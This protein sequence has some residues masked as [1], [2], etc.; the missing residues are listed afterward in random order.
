MSKRRA[1]ETSADI[2]ERYNWKRL[3]TPRAWAPKAGDELAGYYLG[4]TLRDGAFGQYSVVLVAVPSEGVYMVSG[5][6][7]IQL[8]QSAFIPTGSPL[9]IRFDGLAETTMGRQMKK[10][11]VSVPDGEALDEQ[12]IPAIKQGN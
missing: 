6:I 11:E 5:T 10:F 7:I 9:R 3:E 12:S 8:V 4:A 1:K 2:I